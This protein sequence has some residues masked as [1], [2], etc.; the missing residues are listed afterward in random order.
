MSFIVL[1]M[2]LA[3]ALYISKNIHGYLHDKKGDTHTEFKF[4][5]DGIKW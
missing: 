3:S 5:E 1:I 2:F 4:S